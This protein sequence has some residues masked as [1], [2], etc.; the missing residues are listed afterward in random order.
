MSQI[1]V[2][3]LKENTTVLVSHIPG[4]Y[5]FEG[6]GNG[7]SEDPAISADGH[8]VAYQSEATNLTADIL[9]TAS[10]GSGGVSQVFVTE[11]EYD[12][13]VLASRHSGAAGAIASPGTNEHASISGDGKLV[14]WASEG[15]NL[16]DGITVND[17]IYVRNLETNVTTLVSRQT[18]V[19]GPVANDGAGGPSISANG[20]FV[21]FTSGATNL[22]EAPG[23]NS[24]FN[25]CDQVYVRDLVHDI[26]TMV[27]FGPNGQGND[28]SGP[29]VISADGQ[30]VAFES[31]ATNLGAGNPCTFSCIQVYVRE[32]RDGTTT[33]ASRASDTGAVGNAPSTD[34]AISG[35]GDVVGFES[36]ATNLTTDATGGKTPLAFVR[37]V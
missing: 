35:D 34:P 16:V 9:P 14:T 17:Q 22:G 32:W 21:V 37:M 24:G 10:G 15:T 6:R 5:T 30:T 19:N 7:T 27:S 11:L 4:N 13:T 33:V 28:S 3:D 36:D 1:Y 20:K 2:R 25:P 12:T 29:A 8:S 18:G 23:C 31:D 26:T